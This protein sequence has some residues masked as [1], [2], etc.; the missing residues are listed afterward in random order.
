[1]I[2]RSTRGRDRLPVAGKIVLDNGFIVKEAL[3]TSLDVFTVLD[4]DVKYA[5]PGKSGHYALVEYPY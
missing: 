3:V 4:R 2:C 5:H 1:M